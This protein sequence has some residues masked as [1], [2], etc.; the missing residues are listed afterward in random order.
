MSETE[1][2]EARREREWEEIA[3]KLYRSVE[4]VIA[5]QHKANH[6]EMDRLEADARVREEHLQV[7]N[8]AREQA[9]IPH[10]WYM[11]VVGQ[12]D[13]WEDDEEE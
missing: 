13:G 1:S 3:K 4:N 12:Q 8:L 11:R 2:P 5:L 6:G 7:C 10:D 9:G